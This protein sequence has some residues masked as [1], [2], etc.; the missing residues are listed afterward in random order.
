MAGTMNV[1]CGVGRV[2][3]DPET[4]FTKGGERVVNFSL[5]TDRWKKGETDWHQVVV[6]GKAADFCAEYVTKGSSVAIQGAIRY[7]KWVDKNGQNRES[8]KIHA[9]SVDLVGGKRHEDAQDHPTEPRMSQ[10]D[11]AEFVAGDDDVPF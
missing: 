2:G 4:R 3:R 8:T 9:N 10:S 5:A 11:N 7:E 1:W 6:F